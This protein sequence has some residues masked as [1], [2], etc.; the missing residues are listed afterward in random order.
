MVKRE[1]EINWNVRN[2]DFKYYIFD[3]DDNIL[4]MPT[5][6]HLE[7]LDDDGV[8]REISVSTGT[9]AL[10][11]K[12]TGRWREPA[13]GG[14]KAAFRDFQ[15]SGTGQTTKKF[16]EDCRQAIKRVLDGEKPGPSF[17]TLK[18][19]LCEGRIFAIVTARGHEPETLKQAVRLFI[20]A[21]LSP[22]E[23]RKMMASLR[24]YRAWLDKCTEFGTDEEEMEYYLSMCRFHAVTSEKFKAMLEADVEFGGKYRKASASHRPEVAKEFAIHDFTDHLFN[25][26]RRTGGTGR[27]VAVGFSDDDTG[28]VSA[29]SDFIKAELS[30]H[31]PGFKFVV[32]D[33]SDPSLTNGRKVCVAGQMNLPG[34]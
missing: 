11:R 16:L 29:V 23:R 33:T 22:E 30:R 1:P 13:N 28:N 15:D 3:W 26:L 25:M 24:G 2:R 4:H 14:R 20:A 9:F 34:F 19:T 21:V 10:V 18:K 5:R 6:I 12:D 31:Y 17:N 7:H 32:Y 8:W 27:T